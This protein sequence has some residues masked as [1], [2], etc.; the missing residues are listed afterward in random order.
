MRYDQ[1]ISILHLI[2]TLDIGGAEMMLW[3]LL[4]RMDF[5][6]FSSQ[7]VCVIPPG[8]L[9][10]KIRALGIE[11]RHLGLHR[12]RFEPRA[13]VS[14][15]AM[16]RELRP[17]IV[18]TWL[19]HA[20]L[21]GLLAAKTARR[22]KVVWNIRG[23]NRDLSQYRR[24]TGTTVRLC[25]KLSRFPDVII[26][27]SRQAR[28]FHI[29]LGYKAREWEVIPNGFDLEQFKPN[30]KA[31]LNLLEELGVC[32]NW[33]IAKGKKQREGRNKD[34]FFLIGL[35]AR[36]DPIKDHPSFINAACLLLQK[37][38]DVHFVLV[39][40][41]VTWEN[42]A[43]A[44]QI[45]HIWKDHFHLLGERNDIPKIAAAIDIASL[46]SYGEGFPNAIGEAMA[47]GI[48]CVVTDVGDSA[49]IVGETG[50]VVP[51]RNPTALAG[52]I[53]ELLELSSEE[54]R[55]LGRQARERIRH[56]YSLDRIVGEY[57]K[58]YH[59]LASR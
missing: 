35:I 27:N 34:G 52:S 14:L 43:L 44:K 19:Y 40:R 18:Q 9:G 29:A 22:G 28:D 26:A 15:I 24:L 8:P 48:P 6:R 36:Y 55:K 10:E 54:R 41:D 42:K 51:P 39:G 33:G 37:R 53:L 4:S 5:H 7:V 49:R 45:P 30:E 3:K 47:C 16:L 57:E 13:L 11:V 2:T 50:K 1:P 25:T 12:G 38:R 20:D 32:E 23:S 59:E 46:T 31:R 56:H 58:L 21:L 17:D